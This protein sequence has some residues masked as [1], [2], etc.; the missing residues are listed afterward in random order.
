MKNFDDA[1]ASW[2]ATIN[3]WY[4]LRATR[5]EVVEAFNRDFKDR[6]AYDGTSYV[7]MFFK[8]SD[9]SWTMWL[10]TSDRE[11][12]ADS[13]E[14]LRGNPPLPTY[15]DLEARLLNKVPRQ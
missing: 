4:S 12:L 14:R 11:Q 2:A 1:A 13:V 8:S 5:E 7:E 15:A 3:D 9:G 6:E 10:D